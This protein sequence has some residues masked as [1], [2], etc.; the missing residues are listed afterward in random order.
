MNRLIV[1][2]KK[3]LRVITFSRFDANFEPLF[4]RLRVMSLK[5]RLLFNCVTHIFKAIH[6]LSS[7]N[8]CNYFCYKTQIFSARNAYKLQLE[9]PFTRLKVIK[10]TIFVKGVKL[11]NAIDVKVRSAK[12]LSQFTNIVKDSI[13]DIFNSC[14]I[15]FASLNAL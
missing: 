14:N 10:N 3:A 4:R 1:L 8:S 6:S 12:M 9:I 5:E 7:L 13:S 11:Y 15:R 2:Q